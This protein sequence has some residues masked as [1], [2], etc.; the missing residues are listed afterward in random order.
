MITLI[1]PDSNT[2]VLSKLDFKTPPIGLAYIA[3]VLRE[4]GFNV[5]IIDN[6][7]EKLDLNEIIRRIRDSVVVGITTTTPTFNTALK[8]AK[9]IKQA[10]E[11]VFVVL[12]GIHVSFLPYSALK[13]EFVDA[14]CISEGEY[15]MLELAEKIE[16]GKSPEGVKGLIYKE[17]GKIV[18]N[19]RRD[20]I[21][22]LDS[23]PFPAYDLLPL[24][25][26]SILGQKLEHFPMM[27]SRGCPFSC[28]YC[29]SSL[30][31]GKRFRARSA[32][33]VVDEM[34]WLQDKFGAK[35]IAFS[36]DTFTLSKKRVEKICNEV[37]GRCLDVEWSC[38][39]RVDTINEEL[40]KKMKSAGCNCIYYGVESANPKILNDYYR[41]KISLG[42][43][44]TAVKKT[45]ENDIQTV[46]SFIIGAPMETKEDMMKTLKF[47]IKLNPDYAQYSILT[48]YPGTEIYREAK[49]KGWLLTENFD[50]YTCGKPV[51]KNF[52]LTPREI[53]KFLRYCYMR[54]YLRPRF[55]FKEIKN[56][57][58]KI[59]FEIIKKLLFRSGDDNG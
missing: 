16:R 43:V 59:M 32:E 51:L 33:N 42:Q 5:R 54:F 15:T 17:N 24:E 39:S 56:K 8:Y 41:K 52:Y 26:Y 1:N 55:I 27:S 22:D 9:K 50:E 25:K 46:C 40:I 21:R 29:A 57:N 37:K 2:E 45:K 14:V 10:L 38:S 49:E 13:Y 44:T 36:D 23:L 35:Y 4:N 11:N 31:M 58:I 34:E 7:V 48:P 47:S 18:D 3:S 30:F 53:S 19:G 28:R 6:V 12:G 20:F